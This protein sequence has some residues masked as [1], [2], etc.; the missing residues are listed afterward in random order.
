M[1]RTMS[2]RGWSPQLQVSTQGQNDQVQVDQNTSQEVDQPQEQLATGKLEI[3]HTTNGRIRIRATDDSCYSKLETISQNLQQ[4]QGVQEVTANQQTGSLVVKFDATVL[5]LSQM[6]EILQEFDVQVS[7]VSNIDAL[8]EWKSLDFWQEQSISLI[9]L[10][11]GLAVTGRLGIHGFAA[12]PVYM[13][14]ADATRRVINYL[15]PQLSLLDVEKIT[16]SFVATSDRLTSHPQLVYSV[17]HAIPG[18]IRFHLPLLAEDRAYGR[19]LEKLI[20]TDP[21]VMSV[22]INYSA[23]SIAIAYQPNEVDITH[24]VSL[25]ELALKT[26]PPTSQPPEVIHQDVSSFWSDMKPSA[27]SFSLAYIANLPL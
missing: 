13:I 5:S 4:H 9:P 16:S 27:M 11:T 18:R 10:I 1:I 23:A 6:L 21:Q 15:E 12:I 25:M 24:W 22:R 8:A 3:V 7:P 17:A 19:R 20:K 14:T 2:S 26:N